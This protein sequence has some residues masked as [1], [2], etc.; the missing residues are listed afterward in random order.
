MA[1]KL[2]AIQHCAVGKLQCETTERLSIVQFALLVKTVIETV[3]GA[4]LVTRSC[5]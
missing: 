3:A 2:W 1:A 4:T 5:V